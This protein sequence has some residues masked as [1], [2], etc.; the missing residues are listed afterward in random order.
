MARERGP[1]AREDHTSASRKRVHLVPRRASSAAASAPSNNA[2]RFPGSA[3]QRQE[4]P[5]GVRRC[6]QRKLDALHREARVAGDGEIPA[7]RPLLR[8]RTLAA[9]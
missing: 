1:G 6:G 4:G 5:D 3:R 2:K 8:R 9:A 7:S